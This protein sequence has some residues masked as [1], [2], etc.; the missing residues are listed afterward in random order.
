MYLVFMKTTI[1]SIIYNCLTEFDTYAYSI[2][3]TIFFILYSLRTLCTHINMILIPTSYN[4]SA[5]KF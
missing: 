2:F 1:F 5:T 3:K 4:N